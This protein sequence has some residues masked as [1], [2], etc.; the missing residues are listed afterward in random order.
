MRV[1][2]YEGCGRALAGVMHK[3]L[4]GSLLEKMVA[5][6]GLLQEKTGPGKGIGAVGGPWEFNLRDVLRWCQLVESAVPSDVYAPPN[7]SFR[8]REGNKEVTPWFQGAALAP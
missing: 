5:F 7:R 4:P 8:F 2:P 6:V 1:P 3:R